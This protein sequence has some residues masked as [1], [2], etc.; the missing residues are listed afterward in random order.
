[1]GGRIFLSTLNPHTGHLTSGVNSNWFAVTSEPHLT[2]LYLT[3]KAEDII[4]IAP[5]D[6]GNRSELNVSLDCV[7]KK[8]VFVSWV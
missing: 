3:P 4:L 6:V 8:Y 5:I 1:M 7:I 2:H